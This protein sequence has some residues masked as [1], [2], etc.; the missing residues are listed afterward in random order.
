MYLQKVLQFVVHF[1]HAYTPYAIGVIVILAILA[2]ARPKSMAKLLGAVLI[3][4]F[5]LY[6]GGLIKQGIDSSSG[7]KSEM[8]HATEKQLN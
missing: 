3:A 7:K 2:W 4:L 5:L 6:V 1:Y 8:V